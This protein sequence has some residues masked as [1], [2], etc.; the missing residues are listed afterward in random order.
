MN[1]QN[2]VIIY[3]L[4]YNNITFQKSL[5]YYKQYTWAVP[6]I[7]K[8]QNLSFENAFWKQL[9]EIRG[10]WENCRM[11]G[12]IAHSAMTKVDLNTIDK[13]IQSNRQPYFHFANTQ[14]AIPNETTN[15]HPYFNQIWFDV[16]D[17]LHLR[18]VSENNFNYWM[19][20]P[21]LMLKFI[22]WYH[23]ICLPTLMAHPL[24]MHNS[25]HKS[26][27]SEHDLYKL[28]GVPFYP[29]YPF[30]TERLHKS[31]FTSPQKKTLCI[32]ACHT[33]SDIKI[34]SLHA[35]RPYIKEISDDV[36]YINSS[37]FQSKFIIKNMQ[38]TPN[39]EL[40]CYSKF[41]YILSRIDLNKYENFILT[42]DS[43]VIVNSLLP[44]QSLFH[45][46]CEMTSL[47]SS[48]Q[49]R[50]H[51]P[52]FLR[53]YNRQGVCKIIQLYSSSIPTYTFNLIRNVE[54]AH[55]M[56]K[57][58]NVLYPAED[59]TN[60]HF[61][62]SKVIRYINTLNYPV[63]KIKHIESNIKYLTIPTDFD[64]SIYKS[65]QS[66]LSHMSD[67]EA[68]DHFINCGMSEGRLYKH[69]QI[70][71]KKIRDILSTYNIKTYMLN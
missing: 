37:E 18:N 49:D 60:P 59:N 3:V 24:I 13:V 67:K 41:L 33:S 32:V 6:I 10:E 22:K 30:I 23:S 57:T 45:E 47:C 4:C 34:E 54:F 40:L 14:R 35:S 42:N 27:L 19:C 58:T 61:D 8:Y 26:S 15:L 17:T 44:F 64:A 12:T 5:L 21:G 39:N 55:D 7:M 28:C 68:H 51:Y 16:L 56:F 11:V 70:K 36:I 31:F 48:L 43:I 53:R 46:N 71:V 20:T 9:E 2:R 1:K 65:I 52:D 50:H 66:D 63:L 38:Y 29:H 62:N 25:N 69:N